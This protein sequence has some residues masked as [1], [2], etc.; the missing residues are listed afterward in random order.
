MGHHRGILSLLAVVALVAVAVRQAPPTGD[1]TLTYLKSLN[2]KLVLVDNFV[3]AHEVIWARNPEEAQAR[4][5]EYKLVSKPLAQKL[6]KTPESPLPDPI[7][8]TFSTVS[9]A[10]LEQ[11]RER[12]NPYAQLFDRYPADAKVKVSAPVF[13]TKGTTAVFLISVYKGIRTGGVSLVVMV[14]EDGEWTL[15]KKTVLFVS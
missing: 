3:P 5:Y 8:E 2:L 12:G 11:F 15:E 14:Y 6:A 7:R 10:E 9:E 4:L 1:P 13:D